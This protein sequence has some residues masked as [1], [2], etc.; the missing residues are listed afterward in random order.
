[1]TKLTLFLFEISIDCLFIYDCSVI[2]VKLESL[3]Y[4]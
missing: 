3:S 2:I 4:S 1:M